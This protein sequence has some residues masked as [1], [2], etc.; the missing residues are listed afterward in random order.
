MTVPISVRPRSDRE[1]RLRFAR[2]I[3]SSTA[4]TSMRFLFGFATLSTFDGDLRPV[5]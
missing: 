1:A 5:G 3:Q 2:A 4:T